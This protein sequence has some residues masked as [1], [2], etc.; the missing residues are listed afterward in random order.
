MKKLIG[1]LVALTVMVGVFVVPVKANSAGVI[2]ELGEM[3][4]EAQED[5]EEKAETDRRAGV[6][7]ELE[8]I[9]EEVGANPWQENYILPEEPEPEPEITDEIRLL[10]LLTEAEAEGEPESGKRL[11]IDTVLNRCESDEWPDTITNVIYQKGQYAV[12]A[13]G[14]IWRVPLTDENLALV[15]QEMQ[16]RYNKEV[17]FFRTKHYH[18]ARVSLF[19]VGHHYFSK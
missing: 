9:Y 12:I 18:A 19:Q 2:A 10:A 1:F 13:N 4:V 14:R 17:I 6:F 7:K 11:V 5:A 8:E 3:L 15:L 16:D